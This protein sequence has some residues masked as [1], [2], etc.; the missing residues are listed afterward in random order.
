MKPGRLGAAAA[1]ALVA[2]TLAGCL[3]AAT[4][5]AAPTPTRA[6]DPTP[7]VTTY[8]LGTTV[9][10]EGLLLHFDRAVATLDDRGGPVEVMLRIEN[11]EA[12]VGELDGRIRLSIGTIRADATR[13][14]VVPTV[15]AEGTVSVVMTFELQGVVSADTAVIEVG[16]APLHIAKVPLTPAAGP[17]VVFE[18]LSFELTGAATS[19]DLRITLR[20]GLLR[21]DLPD[22]SQELGAGLQA[23]TV[24]YDASYVGSFAGGLAF[25]RDNVVLR[26]PD[27]SII[28]ARRDGRSQSAELIGAGKTRKNLFSRFEIPAG[29]TG[30]FALLVRNAG[31]EKAI[32]FTIGG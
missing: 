12:E 32:P 21:W 11:P 23:L 25:T 10:Y 9:W 6:P 18:P 3:D 26:L 4:P 24:T 28:G 1:L 2:A 30:R 19:A 8:E 16:D 31:T 22:W 5:S 15:P 14:S 7:T 29:A 13:E 20:R 17:P 27:G